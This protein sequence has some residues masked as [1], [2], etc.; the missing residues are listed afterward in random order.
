ML[1]DEYDGKERMLSPEENGWREEEEKEEEVW[2]KKG[3][4]K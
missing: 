2:D 3:E 1:L 4:Q